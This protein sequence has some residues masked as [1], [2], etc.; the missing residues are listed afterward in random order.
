M[1]IR[2]EAVS[3]AAFNKWVA[4]QQPMARSDD[5]VSSGRNRFLEMACANCHTIRGTE[6]SGKFGPD[7]THLM[8]RQTLASGVIENNRDNLTRWIANPE[9]VK[10]G[11]RMPNMRLSDADVKSIVDYLM[12]LE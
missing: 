5:S 4:G 3:T 2:V 9:Q 7:L 6:A 10:P 1:M 12:T 11:C 8:S